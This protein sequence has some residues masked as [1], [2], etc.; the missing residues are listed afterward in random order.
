MT[1]AK[2]HGCYSVKLI[3]SATRQLTLMSAECRV[4]A[5]QL[6]LLLHGDNELPAASGDGGQIFSKKKNWFFFFSLLISFHRHFLPKWLQFSFLFFVICFHFCW[7]NT[8]TASFRPISGGSGDPFPA[9]LIIWL[10]LESLILTIFCY[11]RPDFR[12]VPC[13]LFPSNWFSSLGGRRFSLFSPK[14]SQILIETQESDSL[15]SVKVGVAPLRLN[16]IRLAEGIGFHYRI[17]PSV[18]MYLSHF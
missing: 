2:F 16:S 10:P 4:H 5:L 1:E 14:K 18:D 12:K 9:C 6:S 7:S 8:D 17:D 15:L 13:R 3:Y 11:S